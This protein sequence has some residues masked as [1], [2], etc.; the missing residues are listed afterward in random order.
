MNVPIW[1]LRV[2]TGAISDDTNR[3]RLIQRKSTIRVLQQDSGRSSNRAN[4]TC[5]VASHVDVLSLADVPGVEVHG[6]EAGV[7]AEHVPG[8]EDTRGEILFWVP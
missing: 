4:K 5:V 2:R 1:S 6:R 7:L 8:C 3:L